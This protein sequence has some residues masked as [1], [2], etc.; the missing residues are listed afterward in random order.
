MMLPPVEWVRRRNQKNLRIRV[1]HD[2]IIVSAP[3][4]ASVSEMKR[5]YKEKENWIKESYAGLVAKQ[6]KTSSQNR[7]QQN[8]LLYNG[9]WVPF[10]IEPNASLNDISFS[11]GVF[12]IK[13]DSNSADP[14]LIS[15]LYA[16]FAVA[17]LAPFFSEVAKRLGYPFGRLT[18]R[19]QKTKW[20]SCS[21]KGNIN[22]NWRLIKCPPFV[23]EYI[24]IHELCHLKHLDHSN[25]FWNLVAH[26]MPDY[27]K[28]EKWL[29]LNGPIVF[30][31]P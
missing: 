29:K 20:G 8:E 12:S 11:N 17:E 6:K 22:L 30:Q 13:I 19:N 2:A 9:E 7:F 24:F 31:S 26:H 16:N 3:T 23:Q 4:H 21:G 27:L 10:V 15:W 1:K 25:K 28:A 18:F 5:F 14:E